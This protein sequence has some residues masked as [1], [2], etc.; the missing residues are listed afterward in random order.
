MELWNSKS[1][2]MLIVV[3]LNSGDQS[4]ASQPAT[5]AGSRVQGVGIPF[6][7]VERASHGVQ[8]TPWT[9][10]LMLLNFGSTRYFWNDAAN[11]LARGLLYEYTRYGNSATLQCCKD[12]QTAEIISCRSRFFK[13]TASTQPGNPVRKGK[14]SAY[15]KYYSLWSPKS[16]ASTIDHVYQ[17]TGSLVIQRNTTTTAAVAHGISV[18]MDFSSILLSLRRPEPKTAPCSG[19]FNS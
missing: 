14:Q 17:T 4:T 8:P 18:C 19:I 10:H 5:H 7:G 13:D 9:K 15:C 11:R 2:W 1:V 12:P 16:Q 6:A 3:A